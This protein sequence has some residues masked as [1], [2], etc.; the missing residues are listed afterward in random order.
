[1]IL[2]KSYPVHTVVRRYCVTSKFLLLNQCSLNEFTLRPIRD[3][4]DD[5]ETQWLK[6]TGF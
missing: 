2:Y 5:F 6:M 1:M 3:L 4:G